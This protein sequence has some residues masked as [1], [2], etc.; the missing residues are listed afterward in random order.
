MIQDK[1]E[2]IRPYIDSEIVPVMKRIS[3][4]PLLDPILAYLFPDNEPNE[5]RKQVSSIKSVEEFQGKIMLSSIHS[6]VSKTSTSL[7]YS[8]LENISGD[9]KHL[10]IS[11]HRDIILDSGIIQA[12]FYDNNLPTSEMAVGDNLITEQFIED[13]ARS[14]KMIKVVRSTNPRELYNS[15]SLLSEYIRSVITAGKSSVWIAQRNGR[16]K[17]GID[18]TEQGLLKMFDM[19]GNGNFVD[20]FDELSIVPI[21]ISYEYEPC[22]H[23]KTRELYISRRQKY[24]K[25]AGEDI[26]SILTGIIQEKGAIHIHFGKP[27]S[28]HELECISELEKNEKFKALAELI[29]K[30]IVSGYKLFKTNYIAFDI[31]NDSSDYSSHYTS[32]DREAF[33]A[34]YKAKISELFG[35]RSEIEEIMLSIYANP[36]INRNRIGI[37]FL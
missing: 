16:T 25:A 22:D 10:L 37:D 14:N 8:G 28:R 12:I 29:D 17:D 18:V 30:Y 6:I 13:V 26:V 5:L 20:D 1:F 7:T 33:D 34:Y 27:I 2:D 31:L 11:N 23:L 4:H 32:E 24:V 21:S 36:V 19:S 35:D 15:S 3:K 9:K